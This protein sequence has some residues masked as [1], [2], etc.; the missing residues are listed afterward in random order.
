MDPLLRGQAVSILYRLYRPLIFALYCLPL[1]WLRRKH[2]LSSLGWD[3]CRI[4]TDGDYTLY[5]DVPELVP[6]YNLRPTIDISTRPVVARRK[7]ADLVALAA[8]R[9]ADYLCDPRQFRR[10][11]PVAGGFERPGRFTRHGDR[12]HH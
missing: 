11:E 5:A 2:G 8:D 1:N 7:T 9:P 3:L 6:T 12:G 4:F 10:K